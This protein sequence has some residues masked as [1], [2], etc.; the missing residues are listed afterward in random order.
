MLT[1][2]IFYIS[3]ENWTSIYVRCKDAESKFLKTLQ[4]MFWSHSL[5][6]SIPLFRLSAL[7]IPLCLVTMATF[8]LL[9]QHLNVESTVLPWLFKEQEPVSGSLHYEAY[10]HRRLLS[11]SLHYINKRRG[12][13]RLHCRVFTSLETIVWNQRTW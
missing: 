11:R 2:N 7:N 9:H 12:L 1:K 10:K 8:H 6:C 4:S 5:L 3:K 13:F